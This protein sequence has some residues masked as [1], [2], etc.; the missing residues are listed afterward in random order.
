MEFQ[1]TPEQKMIQKVARQLAEE[2]CEP[3]AAE[4]DKEHRFPWEVVQKI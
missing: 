2:V 1:L 4:I 3:L